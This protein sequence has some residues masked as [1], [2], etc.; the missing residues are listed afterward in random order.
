MSGLTL[1]YAEENKEREI[2]EKVALIIRA[3]V[4]YRIDYHIKK[5]RIDF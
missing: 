1:P 3:V 2:G 4:V 5:H